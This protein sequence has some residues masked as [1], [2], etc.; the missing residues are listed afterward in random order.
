MIL[1]III[2]IGKPLHNLFQQ[3]KFTS[4]HNISTESIKN[5]ATDFYE[6]KK[7]NYT[8]DSSYIVNHTVGKNFKRYELRFKIDGNT[9]YCGIPNGK[10]SIIDK[11]KQADIEKLPVDENGIRIAD[12]DGEAIPIGNKNALEKIGEAVENTLEQLKKLGWTTDD[13]NLFNNTFKG[14]KTLENAKSWKLLKEA[15]SKYVFK[16]KKLFEKFTKLN[17]EVQQY[18]AKFSDKDANSTLIKFLDDCED[19]EFLKF[20]NERP[21]LSEAFVGHKNSWTHTDFENIAENLTDM[22]S[23]GVSALQKTQKWIDR[24]SDLAKFGKVTELGRS[25]NSKIVN[26]LRQK[27]GKLFDDLAKTTGIPVQDLQKYDILTEV[28]LET[29]NGFMKADIAFIKINKTTD[30]I[31]DVIIIENKLS[32]S[33][34]FTE[35]QKEGFGAILKGQEQMNIKY[36]PR[37]TDLLNGIKS[38]KLS[39]NKIFKISDGGTDDI[40]KVSIE[41]ITKIR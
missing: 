28:P 6:E 3:L 13:I 14:T 32:K 18:V 37:D 24:S 7:N 19:A 11:L 30:K 29:T 25:L 1:K 33:T 36:T 23:V 4:K 34:A 20:I 9:L 12:I 22:S 41:K 35:R 2:L 27:Q 17:P 26:A 21:N 10:I 5:A 16:D 39:K 38:L 15:G 31:E 40:T 8:S